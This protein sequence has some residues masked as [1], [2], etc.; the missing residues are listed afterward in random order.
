MVQM[1][2]LGAM[3]KEHQYMFPTLAADTDY[4]SACSLTNVQV[5]LLV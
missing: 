2:N 3:V 4:C 1:H 5:Y